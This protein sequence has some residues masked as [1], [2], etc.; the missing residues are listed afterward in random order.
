[1]NHELVMIWK[2]TEEVLSHNSLQEKKKT[3]WPV[4]R[5]RT[6]P[7]ERPPLVSEVSAKFCG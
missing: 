4:F 1:M 3:P 2:E 7:T 6:L 5:Q